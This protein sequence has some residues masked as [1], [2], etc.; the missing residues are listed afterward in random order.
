MACEP[1]RIGSGL[2]MVCTRGPRRVPKGPPCVSCGKPSTALCDFQVTRELACAG[3]AGPST[4][5][6]DQPICERCRWPVPGKVDTDYC[7]AHRDQVMV[8]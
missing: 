8:K 6:C 7:P 1:I 3:H 2:A 4:A 5:V